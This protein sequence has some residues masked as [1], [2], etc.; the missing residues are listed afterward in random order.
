MRALA[1]IH[2]AAQQ[3]LRGKAVTCLLLIILADFLFY[4]HTLGW[5]G[6]L[7]GLGLVLVVLGHN[8]RIIQAP[9]AAITLPLMLGLISALIESPDILP[10]TFFAL[11]IAFLGISR[12]YTR[13][14]N[15][16]TWTKRVLSFVLLTVFRIFSDVEAA[17]RYG[18]RRPNHDRTTVAFR[19]WLL[20]FVLSLVFIVLFA[21]ANPV[22]D[23][24]I[25][26]IDWR[27]LRELFSIKRIAFWFATMIFCWAVI[28]PRLR[29]PLRPD[30][31][32]K[33]DRSPAF[34]EDFIR[35]G[36]VY[37]ALFVFNA[38]FLVQTGLDVTY[39]YGLSELPDGMTFAEYAHRGAYPLIAT[40]LLAA[41]F[42]L[43]ALRPGSVT[44]RI[45]FI[46]MLV[47]VWIAQNVFL[48]LS[49]VWRLSLYVEEY[50]LTY[51]RVAA[52]IWMVCVAAGLVWIK[53]RL[54]YAKSGELLINVNLIT[55]AS[56]L[57]ICCFLK[58]GGFIAD[59]NVAHSRE[60]SGT[61]Q[62]LD[63]GYLRQIGVDALPA[64]Q[65]F[66][67]QREDVT[68]KS[69]TAAQYEARWINEVNNGVTD[70]RAWTYRLYRLSGHIDR[71]APIRNRLAEGGNGWMVEPRQ[72]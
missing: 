36:A 56:I 10:I 18:K 47:Y 25:D 11:G 23:D 17:R 26:Q 22:I 44:E 7:F 38:L 69:M 64:V 3:E 39:L 45:P 55:V 27:E 43:V 5:T 58:F 31:E 35:A 63:L 61:G 62:P 33:L 65:T 70:W 34:Y 41:L 60:I 72:E 15:G 68:T 21:V 57:Y 46:R 30:V 66:L 16:L 42:V 4:D 54:V 20:P 67:D 51:L 28:R 8:S 52:F 1:N 48:V 6:A 19:N 29:L 9:S 53:L 37:R 24:W 49:S 32:E 14:T 12:N 13:L 71:S 40:A 59:Y 2:R 50:S